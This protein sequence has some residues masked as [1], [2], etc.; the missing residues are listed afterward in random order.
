ML[1]EA[2]AGTLKRNDPKRVTHHWGTRR[3]LNTLRQ[4]RGYNNVGS[5]GRGRGIDVDERNHL[6]RG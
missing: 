5:K 4:G 6:D 1:G 3:P 2:Q